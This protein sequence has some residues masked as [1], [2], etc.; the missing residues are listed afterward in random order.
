MLKKL[1][2]WEILIFSE[3]NFSWI[4]TVIVGIAI[5]VILGRFAVRR[6]DE[7]KDAFVALTVIWT[8][9]HLY[10]VIFV[11]KGPAEFSVLMSSFMAALSP[12]S[13]FILLGFMAVCAVRKI[14]GD[15]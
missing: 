15:W 2:Y 14:K 6:K 13:T 11:T 9:F 10:N 7:F 5:G 12:V 4:T 8:L 3:G 1:F